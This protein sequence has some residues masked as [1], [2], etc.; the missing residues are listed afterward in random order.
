MMRRTIAALA[1]LAAMVSPA[2]AQMP[3]A[4]I[5]CTLSTHYLSAAS[6]NSTS[7]TQRQTALYNLTVVNTTAAI[8]YLKLY[9][10][11]SQPT[12]NT[13]VPIAT[14]PIPFGASSAGGSVVITSNTTPLGFN[15]GLGF[16]L[17]GGLADND[18]TNAATGVA[19]N[20]QYR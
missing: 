12:C 2:F 19:I 15:N 3:C 5:L 11:A 14:F 16:C 13:D 20:F 4:L 1:L 6:N 9:D 17:T 8:Y 18:N 7:V 10:K